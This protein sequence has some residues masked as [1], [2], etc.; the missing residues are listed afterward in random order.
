MTIAFD[1]VLG[2]PFLGMITADGNKPLGD[3]TITNIGDETPSTLYVCVLTAIRTANTGS[4]QQ[5]LELVT[6]QWLEVSQDSGSTWVPIGGSASQSGNRLAVSS[7]PTPGN[8]TV[9]NARLNVP[10]GATTAG[11]VVL[12]VEL[13]VPVTA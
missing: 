4:L 13:F 2:S 5:G 7:I 11:D 8:S 9:I 6:E 1:V 3:I 10:T 12:S